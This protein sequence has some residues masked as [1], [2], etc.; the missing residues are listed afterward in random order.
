[1]SDSKPRK[2]RNGR[3]GRTIK[4]YKCKSCNCTVTQVNHKICLGCET[5]DRVN[6]ERKG[7]RKV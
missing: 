1:M 4:T 5:R 7:M 3:S 6:R 2:T